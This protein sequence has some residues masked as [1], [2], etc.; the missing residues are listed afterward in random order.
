MFRHLRKAIHMQF[1]SEPQFI[2]VD[3][4]TFE[5]VTRVFILY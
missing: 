3:K 4:H 2:P 1:K 5:H